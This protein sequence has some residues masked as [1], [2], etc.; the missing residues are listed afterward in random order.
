M[1]PDSIRQI[2]DTEFL[3][4][5]GSHLGH[6]YLIDINERTCDCADFLRIRHCKHIAALNV[7]FPQLCPKVGNGSKIPE[8]AC[9]LDLPKPT[10]RSEEKTAQILLKDINVLC[11]QLNGLSDHQTPDLTALKGVKYSFTVAISLAN[12]SWVLPKKDIFHLN[13]NTWA[14]MAKCMGVGK[15]PK[16]K[17]SLTGRNTSTEC[18]GPVKGKQA[19]KYTDPYAAGKRLG[20]HAKPDAVSVAANEHTCASVPAPLPP[21]PWV[22][23]PACVSP[24][25]A[26]VDSAAHPFTCADQTTANL[27]AY[28]AA[29]T[30]P[31]PAF[32]CFPTALPSLHS[33][34]HA[35]PSNVAAGFA[36]HSFTFSDRSTMGPLSLTCLLGVSGCMERMRLKWPDK[37]T[38]G[39]QYYAR[40]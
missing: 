5:S 6:H 30:V 23:S 17:P 35:P 40:G 11:Q 13:R 7:H 27:L 12:G 19:C 4:A 2:S 22:D 26:A 1:S 8:R 15:A 20:K 9:V 34:A 10:A 39:T 31:G 18:I 36:A 29:G 28:P 38:K 21:L 16:W 25:A 14:E 3:V 24:S 32:P 33:S 37:V